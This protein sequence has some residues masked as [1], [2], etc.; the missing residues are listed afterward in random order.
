MAHQGFPLH[1][2][3]EVSKAGALSSGL[4]V[5]RTGKDEAEQLY[6]QQVSK[7]HTPAKVAVRLEQDKDVVKVIKALPSSNL[8]V[9]R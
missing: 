9:C 6:T 3:M 2:A 5:T 4:Y 7:V 1:Q 8:I